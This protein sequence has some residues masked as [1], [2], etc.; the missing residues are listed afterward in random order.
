V[1]CHREREER[2][3]KELFTT[4]QRSGDQDPQTEPDRDKELAYKVFR[5]N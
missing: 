3:R 2:G 5:S 4:R 1:Y